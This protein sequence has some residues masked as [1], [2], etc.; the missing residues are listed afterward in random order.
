MGK[1]NWRLGK[2]KI[3]I[4]SSMQSNLQ[5]CNKSCEWLKIVPKSINFKPPQHGWG[6]IICQK[7]FAIHTQNN[8]SG[9]N[10]ILRGGLYL[11][12]IWQGIVKNKLR[13]TH[14][15]MRLG[16]VLWFEHYSRFNSWYDWEGLCNHLK[17]E[18]QFDLL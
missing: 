9:L 14:V 15:M 17:Y 13:K 2:T 10:Q 5:F 12:G 16:Y 8:L 4:I 7:V 6:C 18:L 1:I 11:T 3:D